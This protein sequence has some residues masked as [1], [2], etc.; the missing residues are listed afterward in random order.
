MS[1]QEWSSDYFQWSTYMCSLSFWHYTAVKHLVER[2]IL[3]GFYAI[4]NFV[5]HNFQNWK[6]NLF[7]L[8]RQ[9][10]HSLYKYVYTPEVNQFSVLQLDGLFALVCCQLAGTQ[11]YCQLTAGERSQAL[12]H[13]VC[14]VAQNP[15]LMVLMC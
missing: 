3:G 1:T 7:W 12:Q 6:P 15:E 2:I 8:L 13:T 4:N 9:K 10:Q 14:C 5:V 11:G